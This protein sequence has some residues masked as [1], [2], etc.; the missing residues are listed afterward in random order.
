MISKEIFEIELKDI[1]YPYFIVLLF[2]ISRV[3]SHYLKQNSACVARH[4]K[5]IIEI[6]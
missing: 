5:S 1:T 6:S 2:S 4:D 3:L